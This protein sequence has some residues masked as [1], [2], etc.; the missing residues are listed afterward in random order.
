MLEARDPD[1]VAGIVDRRA[2]EFLDGVSQ[3]RIGDVGGVL[4]DDMMLLIADASILRRRRPAVLRASWRDREPTAIGRAR[5]L[6]WRWWGGVEDGEHDL[7]RVHDRVASIRQSANLRSSASF[8]AHADRTCA[9]SR[10][11][12]TRH[13]G[14]VGSSPESGELRRQRAAPRAFGLQRE[15]AARL[16]GSLGS[17]MALRLPILEQAACRRADRQAPASP[18]QAQVCGEQ[19]ADQEA[20]Q[21]RGDLGERIGPGGPAPLATSPSL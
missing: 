8:A 6:H 20:Q 16:G 12:F 18:P 9:A 10:I 5:A 4:L 1:D 21:Q 3:R 11:A 19:R 17:R 7:G 2:P 14:S 13:L 15:P